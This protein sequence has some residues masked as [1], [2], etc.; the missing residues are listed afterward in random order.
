MVETPT[1]TIN[2]PLE[3]RESDQESFKEYI[4]HNL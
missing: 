1:K 2:I 4:Q 3:M